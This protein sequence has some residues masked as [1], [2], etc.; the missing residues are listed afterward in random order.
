MED[1]MTAVRG[2]FRMSG[3]G[4]VANPPRQVVG[5]GGGKLRVTTGVVPPLNRMAVKVSPTGVFKSN[6]GRLMVLSEVDSGKILALMEVFI[7]GTLRTGAAT[8]IA[9]DLLANPDGHRVG[10][11]GSGRQAK[12]QLE[13]VAAVRTVSQVTVFSPN[14]ERL[15]RFCRE[16]TETLGRPVIAAAN[17]LEVYDNE[18]LISATTSQE[19]V[20]LGRHLRPGTHINAIGA[21]MLN[22]VELDP[23]AVAACAV[24]AVD[25]KAQAREESLALRDAVERGLISWKQ[26][27]EIGRVAAGRCPGRREANALTLFKSLGV[28][29]EDVA[30]GARAYELA[31]E[32]GVGLEVPLTEL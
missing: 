21:N 18:I 30:L 12:T 16:S 20:I 25:N 29:M 1:A 6:A 15:A 3:E 9:T 4:Q 17:P 11:F 2:V 26:V 10:L 8:G 24:I 23:D 27:V 19:P 31:R 13:A 14:R 32:R 28:A 22:R 7:L 5:L